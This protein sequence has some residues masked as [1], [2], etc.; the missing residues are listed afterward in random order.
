MYNEKT[1]EK[2]KQK[3]LDLAIRGKLV[4][5]DPNDEPASVLIEKIRK[6]KEKLI[7]E[8]K[9]KKPKEDSF[10][11]KGSDNCYYENVNEEVKC[12][13]DEIPFE[14]PESW[15]W[16]RLGNIFNV[17]MG[18]SPL[19]NS[20]SEFVDGMEFHQ[21]KLFFG[22][23]YLK[24]SN[25][26][27]TMPTK[28]SNENSVLLCIR[29]PVGKVN[30]NK[31]KI[32]IGRGLCSIEHNKYFLPELLYYFFLNFEQYFIYKSTG[33]TFKSITNEVVMN[34]I[35]PIPPLKEQNNIVIKCNELLDLIDNI[36]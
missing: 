34:L 21:G 11:F 8:G 26:K 23:K 33:S 27:T 36:Q 5:Q 24:N 18:Q 14:I 3:I 6:E 17:I 12:I 19:G 32:C 13:Q 20:I 28:I 15:V 2:L 16:C 10:I 25:T 7:K 22:N 4:P 1:I 30:I 31:R 29:A 9:I 35:L